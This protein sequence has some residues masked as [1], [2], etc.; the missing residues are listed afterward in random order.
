MSDASTAGYLMSI[1]ATNNYDITSSAQAQAGTGTWTL[2]QR[3]NDDATLVDNQFSFVYIAN[4]TAN[5][6][7]GRV[8]ADG[9]LDATLQAG[10]PTITK[11]NTGLYR[12]TLPGVT[13]DDGTLLLTE[14]NGAPIA[15]NYTASGADF[16]VETLDIPSFLATDAQ[17]DFVFAPFSTPLTPFAPATLSITA[18]DATST[19]GGSVTLNADGSF[20]YD[21]TGVSVTAG[22]SVDDT[23]TYT[24]TDGNAATSTATVTVTVS[25][26]GPDVVDDSFTLAV[27]QSG[28][29][30]LANDTFGQ[31]PLQQPGQTVSSV[32]FE[33]LPGSAVQASNDADWI[34]PLDANN[35]E[36]R[37]HIPGAITFDGVQ[38]NWGDIDLYIDVNGDGSVLQ[39]MVGTDGVVIPTITENRSAIADTGGYATAEVNVEGGG[40]MWIA[41]A[42]STAGDEEAVFVSAAYFPFAEGWIGGHYDEGIP[43]LAVVNGGVNGDPT[44][45]DIGGGRWTVK[46][47]G[48][49]DSTTD[50]VLFVVGGS[51][52]DNF[53][54]SR[55]LGGDSWEVALR[56]NAGAA[57][58]GEVDDFSFVYV[59]R[60]ATGLIGGQVI[61]DA[62]VAN[63]M[64]Q[65]VGDFTIQR[66]AAGEWN[67]SI[68]GQSPE[69]GVLI[70]QSNDPASTMAENVFFS[71]DA[72]DNGTDFVIHQHLLPTPDT[73]TDYDFNFLFI[74]FDNQISQTGPLTV[75]QF[76]STADPASG[77][78][79]LG[80]TLT[81]NADGTIGYDAGNAIAPLGEG[82]VLTDTFVY[83][84][85]DGTANDTATVTVTLLGV[86]DAP[87]AVEAFGDLVLDEDADPVTLSFATAFT[88]I[89]N[90]DSV[91]L[92]V[93]SSQP[94]IVAAEM[95]SAGSTDV[96]ITP[97]ANA[98][99]V[100]KITV[101]ATDQSGATASISFFV[102]L[103]P[104]VDGP[105]ATADTEAVAA[106][107][108]LT[109]SVL[110]NDFHA[111]DGVYEVA[112]ANITVDSTATTNATS[113]WT[114]EQTGAQPNEMNVLSAGNVGDVQIGIN[115]QTFTPADGVLYGTMRENIDPFGTVN[116]YGAFGTYGFATD[117]GVGG[118]ERNAPLGA[119]FFP[120]ADGW[121]GG[122]VAADGTLLSGRGVT[123]ANI[124]KLGTGFF[125]V[126][127]PGVTDSYSD[128]FLF[129]ITQSNDDNA[130]AARPIGGN[131][132]Q[133]RQL[134]ND[135]DSSG[136]EDDAWSFV[137][138]PANLPGLVA[139]RY[140]GFSE[141][142]QLDQSVGN[143]TLAETFV[144]P[145]EFTLT[146]PGA[147]PTDGVLML[148]STGSQFV[149]EVNA[150]APDNRVLN[151]TASGSDFTI[152]GRQTGD[153]APAATSFAF[154]YVPFA[155]PYKLNG[156]ADY[157][158]VAFDATSAEGAT[159]TDNGDGTFGYD[160]SSSATL[161]A[162]AAGTTLDDTFT[163]TIEDGNG[164]QSIGTVTVT[165]SGAAAVTTLT[166]TADNAT[167]AEDAVSAGFTVTR[168][169]DLTAELVVDLSSS[170]TDVG[171]V[172]TS[173]TIPAGEA[174]AVF[175]VGIVNNDFYSGTRSVE[176]TASSTGV[177]AVMETLA[178]TDDEAGTVVI[179]EIMYDA[180]GSEPQGE[181][182]EIFNAGATTIDLGGWYLDDEDANVFTPIPAG[183][184]LPADGV[185]VIFNGDGGNQT[186]DNFR[187]DWSTAADV[188]V[189]VVGVEWGSLANSP[190]STNEILVIR[191]GNGD[192]EDEANYQEDGAG[193]WPTSGQGISFYLTDTA[194]DNNDGTNWAASV[195]GVDGVVNSAGAIWSANDVGS[196]GFVPGANDSDV[197]VGD[198]ETVTDTTVYTGDTTIVKT[199]NG[200]LILNLANSHTGGLRVEAGTVII[201]NAAA[202]NAGPLTVAAGAKVMLEVGSSLV[203]LAS[204]TLDPTAQLDVGAGGFTVAD[205]GFTAADI[206]AAL[207]S[208]RNG[209]TW[210]GTA[211]ITYTVQG[212]AAAA[213]SFDVGYIVDANGVLTV[214]YTGSGDAQLDGKIDFDDIL[215]LFPNYGATGSFV[216]SE[217]DFTYDGKVD[218]DDILA[219]FPNYGA[220]AVFGAGMLGSG[221]GS[222]TGSGDA[223]GVA[224]GQSTTTNGDTVQRPVMGPEAPADLPT[225]TPT[226]L[227]RTG[228][229][230]PD[231]TTM[232]FAA[233]A[234]DSGVSSDKD[235]KK[236]AFATL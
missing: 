28:L 109:I 132:W 103:M 153:F 164:A 201:Q 181:W 187:A 216:W 59:P 88:D 69:T 154:A 163:Y 27:G 8:A 18:F 138:I 64:R 86:N 19:L 21:P 206:R 183:T 190:S 152:Q 145:G 57:T 193:G 150:E 155:S 223:G 13:P 67:L 75:D 31:P 104:A 191:N 84:A 61:G 36:Q 232:A 2:R 133:Y 10:S 76:G 125:E 41:T 107:G 147:S 179:T 134:D 222:S 35:V 229:T 37:S 148:V 217:G 17:F 29:N 114:V 96:V 116:T 215:A 228:T 46:I 94:G 169:G 180:A 12:L 24:V 173:V 194:S 32:N 95:A 177:A 91:T 11:E 209:G 110:A 77:L 189:I 236:S 210:N 146:I 63:P 204:L 39:H 200:T 144:N 105:T 185:A 175:N 166:L 73:R 9:T 93:A 7:A 178:V 22:T 52:E 226:T 170:N 97:Q 161:A 203:P 172:E 42:S 83:R 196:P 131:A 113:T 136:F 51:N 26:P 219:L 1:G 87:V 208:G 159:I 115:G 202:L 158:I 81:L 54:S 56:D 142:G 214:R 71:Y 82:D 188:S 135:S 160:P 124:T 23:F 123:P 72:A 89:D 198:G 140:T 79:D 106:D 127:I 33:Y 117:T 230:K 6:I 48:V 212:A 98:F 108:T 49:A 16:L 4:D 205:G 74:P 55:P 118:G 234:S 44:V 184:L 225:R 60:N 220:D 62:T 34:I 43:G 143:F 50:G 186:A 40:N 130:F 174:S 99:G 224:A 38:Q 100:A 192:V 231:A 80:N 111:D 165:V 92:S 121:T 141:G 233:L 139:G 167:V 65:S 235:T 156:Y 14:S 221:G 207:I 120:F 171:T 211:G 15:L 168:A 128:G 213:T 25:A 126:S 45:T 53:A 47:P 195:A 197:S 112:A 119:A 68:P 78:S 157:S 70:F 199:G 30:V 137:Y 182:V 3:Y 5:L 85:T 58:G 227:S 101:T 149:A 66:A 129:A 90:G 218:F 151:Y 102:T 162:L 20:A 176:I 122:H